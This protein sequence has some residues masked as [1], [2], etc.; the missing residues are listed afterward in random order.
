MSRADQNKAN[1][2]CP[3]SIQDAPVG[4]TVEAEFVNA[5]LSL[6]DCLKALRVHHWLKNFLIFVPLI[7]GHAWTDPKAIGITLAGLACLL[8]VTSTTYLLND[9]ADLDSDRRHWSKRNA[10][11]ANFA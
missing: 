2:L 1:W 9:I 4:K 5:P 6:R 8:L 3:I 10:L 7:L 11:C